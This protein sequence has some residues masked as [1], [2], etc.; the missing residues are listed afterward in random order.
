[1]K[2]PTKKEAIKALMKNIAAELMAQDGDGIDVED[3]L[4]S[5]TYHGEL[6]VIFATAMDK[7][8]LEL[9]STI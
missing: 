3:L 8:L 5:G 6:T 9:E 4:P 2:Q 7:T 1:M